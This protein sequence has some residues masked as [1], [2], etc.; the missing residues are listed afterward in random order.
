MNKGGVSQNLSSVTNDSFCYE[1]VKS[2]LLIGYQQ[3][4]HW[5]LSFV[6]EKRLCETPPELWEYRCSRKQ[7][8]ISTGAGGISSG[9][10]AAST[11]PVA[12]VAVAGVVVVV[13]AEAEEDLG[14]VGVCSLDSCSN[15]SRASLTPSI[16][17]SSSVIFSPAL[18]WKG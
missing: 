14:G 15:L 12:K 6:I 16:W 17:L 11:S 8:C 4:F 5:F 18:V 3:I 2:L 10:G 7:T 1:I 9:W 13:V